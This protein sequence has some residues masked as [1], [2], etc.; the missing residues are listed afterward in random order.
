MAAVDPRSD[1]RWH[2]L[3]STAEGSLFTS[4]PWIRSVC[5]TYGFAPEAR[6]VTDAAGRATGGFV[7]VPVSD[8]R[9]DRLV[10][11]PF[12]D[13]AEPI[14]ADGSTWSHLVNDAL[15]TDAP[16]RIRCLDTAVPAADARLVRAEEAAW[17]CT[18]LD[19]PVPEIYRSLSS[20]ARR[21]IAAA[22]RNGVHVEAVTGMD[23]VRIYHRLH[24]LLRKY[25][26][27]LLAQPFAFFERIWQE[28]STN[29]GIVTFL[30]YVNGEPIAGSVYLAWND[31]LYYKFG[32]SL[33]GTLQLRPNDALAWSALRWASERGFRALDWGLSDLDQP[34]LVAYKRKWASEERRIVTLLPMNRDPNNGRDADHLLGELTRLLTDDVVPDQ[35]TES[36]GALLYRY[37]S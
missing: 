34:G 29:D 20:A 24:V 27:R 17:H 18:P 19:A 11:L 22:E 1:P 23:A 37:F 33:A 35:I 9:G 10:S 16:L 13:R 30:A 21:N 2:T 15:R 25:K 31:A 14:G 5:D 28:F 7:W 4:P 3:A 6:I 12:S 36:A 8:I 26:Y 32:A